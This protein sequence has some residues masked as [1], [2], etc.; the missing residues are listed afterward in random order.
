MNKI[1]ERM[2]KKI[3]ILLTC[4]NRRESTLTCLKKLYRQQVTFDVFLVDDGST[5][6]TSDAISTNYPEVNILEGDGNLFWG[7]GMRRAFAEAMKH[8]YDYY[9]W[10]NDDTL[11]DEQAIDELLNI[12]HDLSERGH[13]DS[14]VVGSTRDSATGQPTYG[15][16]VQSKLWYT[17]RFEFVEPGKTCQQCDSFFGN[18]VLIPSSVVDKVGN[19]DDA[20]I[21][22]MGDIDYGL[23][24][25]KLG[26]SVW[27]APGFI[28]TCSRNSI[29]GSW[30]DTQLSLS[31][32]LKKTLQPKAFP[33][34]AWTVF[35][36]RHSGVFWF[37]YWPL[38]YLRSVVG[39]RNLKK[40]P[41]FQQEIN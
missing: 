24:A 3:A 6:G 12:H 38:P 1:N 39:Y 15:G 36:K 32:R 11:L 17:K 5:D 40:S 34:K 33:L 9:L 10:L 13:P 23:R 30:A 26:C 14:I 8:G 31:E 7:G 25:R 16:A 18:C 28:G 35:C 37:V 20:F 2:E 4:Y 22:T 29:A 21:H 41:S 27:S 19:I